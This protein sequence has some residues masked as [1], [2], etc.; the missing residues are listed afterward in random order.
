VT[1]EIYS[2]FAAAANESY[3]LEHYAPL[4]LS[5]QNCNFVRDAFTGITSNYCPPLKHYLDIINVGLGL[6]SVGVLLCLVLW[7]LYAN[8]PQ[9][10]EVFVMLSLKEKIK[11]RFNRNHKSTNLALPN[12]GSEV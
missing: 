7:I 9:R 5:L 3:A 1:P 8:R 2:Q 12:A 6:I 4:L 11:S 10:G